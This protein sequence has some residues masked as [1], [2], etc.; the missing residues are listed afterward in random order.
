MRVVNKDGQIL[1][2]FF[3]A[4]LLL[5]VVPLVVI[6]LVWSIVLFSEMGVFSWQ[7]PFEVGPTS[8]LAGF[9]L[10]VASPCIWLLAMLFDVRFA[11]LS[12]T[13]SVVGILGIFIVG[14]ALL[15]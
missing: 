5:A 9:T 13:L 11:W 15:S 3:F 12:V 2:R 1:A 7:T 14:L 8:A 4:F 6:L 10:L